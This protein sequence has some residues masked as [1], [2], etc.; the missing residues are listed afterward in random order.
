MDIT[1]HYSLIYNSP[2]R[3]ANDRGWGSFS[4]LP[5]NKKR[6]NHKIRTSTKFK[7]RNMKARYIPVEI[8][9]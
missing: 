3:G 4:S 8:C 6:K 2:D 9:S 1:N 5:Q 7:A